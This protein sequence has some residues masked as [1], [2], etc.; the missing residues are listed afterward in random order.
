MTVHAL[1]RLISL[2]TCRPVENMAIDQALLEAVDAGSPPVLRLYSWSEP[3]VSLG[4]FQPLADRRQ[5]ADSQELTCVRRSTGGGAIIHDHELTYSFTIPTTAAGSG[6]R[7]ELYQQT[8]AAMVRALSDF[9]VRAVPV[10]QTIAGQPVEDDAFL[11][12]QRRTQED[13]VVSGYKVLGSAQ[14]KSRRAV[15]QHGSLLL[16]A[17]SWAPQLPGIVNLTSVQMSVAAIAE[18]FVAALSAVLSMDWRPDT[19]TAAERS[20]SKQIEL[21]KFGS[22]A[23]LLKR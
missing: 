13:L 5:H 10:W 9:G 7:H 18:S 6:P 19:L 20:R 23:W 15:L 4:Y 22:P 2:Q 3:T 17:S 1:G 14:R 11:C 21:E 12:F 8:H 16:E